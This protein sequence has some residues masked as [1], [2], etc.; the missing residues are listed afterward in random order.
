M[1]GLIFCSFLDEIVGLKYGEYKY[2]C[3]NKN[4]QRRSGAGRGAA[5]KNYP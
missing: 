4:Q 5:E 3:L 2:T 1:L